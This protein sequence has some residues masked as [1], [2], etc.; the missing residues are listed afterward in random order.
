LADTRDLPDGRSQAG[1]RH[2]KI[3]DERDNLWATAATRAARW[4]PKPTRPVVLVSDA[5]PQWTPV[6]TRTWVPAGHAWVAKARCISIAPLA[7]ALAE[8]NTA[9]KPSPWV[10]ISFPPWEARA[11]RVIPW[12]SERAPAY[13]G[14]PRRLSRAVDPSISVNKNVSVSVLRA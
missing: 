1:D 14:P 10:L 6:R 8:E 3:H 7:Q 9:K 13:A 2:L 12:C 5:S 11:A 4:M